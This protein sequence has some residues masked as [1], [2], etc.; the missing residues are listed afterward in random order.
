[1]GD[2]LGS[3]LFVG[4]TGSIFAALHDTGNLTLT[5]GA[6]LAAMIVVGLAATA[7]SLRIGPVRND[8]ALG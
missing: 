5:F 7:S 2:A 6:L 8:S 4:L 1:V 3:G